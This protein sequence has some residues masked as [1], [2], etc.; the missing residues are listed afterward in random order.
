MT[1]HT[2]ESGSP[3]WDVPINSNFAEIDATLKKLVGGHINP[4]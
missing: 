3:S 4:R 1:I 2:I